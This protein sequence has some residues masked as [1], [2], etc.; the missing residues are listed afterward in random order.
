MG[1]FLEGRILLL[2][3]VALTTQDSPVR[4]SWKEIHLQV[5]SKFCRRLPRAI[6]PHFSLW[7]Q[8]GPSFL[9]FLESQ[10]PSDF[11]ILSH[12]GSVASTR[13]VDN[14]VPLPSSPRAYVF[15]LVCA[16]QPTVYP[17]SPDRASHTL[18][19]PTLSLFLSGP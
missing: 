14:L 7:A 16:S 18:Q 2:T 8:A 11:L 9:Q 12:I 4:G 6:S 1:C 13:P 19:L 10:S 17:F 5:M 15:S 3:F